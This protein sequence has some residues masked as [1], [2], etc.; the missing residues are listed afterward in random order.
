MY[1]LYTLIYTSILEFLVLAFFWSFPL[2]FFS[3]YGFHFISQFL[4]INAE[5]NLQFLVYIKNWFFV[6][7]SL[8]FFLRIGIKVGG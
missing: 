6:P 3:V 2:L 4:T 8:F 1:V 5:V 7:A